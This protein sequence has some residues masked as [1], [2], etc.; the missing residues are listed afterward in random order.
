MSLAFMPTA[1][2]SS[3]STLQIF[4]ETSHLWG[5]LCPPVY[6]LSHFRFVDWLDRGLIYMWEEFKNVY[7]L[8]LTVLR[9]PC[10]VDRTLKSSYY[11][12][13]SLHSGMSRAV[14]P[15][16]F[17]K[18]DVEHRH[19]PIWASHS[20]FHFLSQ[21]HWICEEDGSQLPGGDKKNRQLVVHILHGA[22]EA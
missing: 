18:V 20:T 16:E 3:F 19:I 2:V 15:Q 10:V 1:S 13:Y 6:L 5:L 8:S 14:H 17:L 21:A 9:W 22:W 7:D 4:W 11:F 12:Y